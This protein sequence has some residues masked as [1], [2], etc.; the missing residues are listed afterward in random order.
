MSS[1][2]P[3]LLDPS[4]TDET[5]DTRFSTERRLS[6]NLTPSRTQSFIEQTGNFSS[7]D[8][9]ELDTHSRELL[10]NLRPTES[11]GIEPRTLMKSCFGIDKNISSMQLSEL[12]ML[13]QLCYRARQNL[14]KKLLSVMNTPSASATD[15]S[16]VQNFATS[17]LLH[18]R[19]SDRVGDD[20]RDFL[21]K[22][23]EKKC[24]NVLKLRQVWM[25][26]ENLKELHKIISDQYH[27]RSAKEVRYNFEESECCFTPNGSD[28][29]EEKVDDIWYTF[30]EKQRLS[31]N[32]SSIE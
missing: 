1:S 4:S 12:C 28:V 18:R 3:L 23:I 6:M 14:L 29:E 11:D 20:I 16:T 5:T 26:A 15:A 32:F 9:L 21:R 13:G 19:Q 2:S 7:L 27:A 17:P 31:A 30:S 8:V 24:V 25:E 22:R 10:Q